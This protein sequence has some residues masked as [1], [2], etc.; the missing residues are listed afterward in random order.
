MHGRPRHVVVA[1]GATSVFLHMQGLAL[2][3]GEAVRTDEVV[4]DLSG[5]LVGAEGAIVVHELNTLPRLGWVCKG[6]LVLGRLAQKVTGWA[7]VAWVILVA[8]GMHAGLAYLGWNIHD[9]G[10]DVEEIGEVPAIVRNR[11][12]RLACLP[13]QRTQVED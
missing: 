1:K 5:L 2:L 4:P 11:P 6:P 9:V 12:I 8:R 10:T 7:L 13:S 3:S